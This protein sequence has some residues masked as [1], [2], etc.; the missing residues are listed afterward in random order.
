MI[1]GFN[2]YFE[3]DLEIKCKIICLLVFIEIVENKLW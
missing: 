3:F 2:Y 1:F